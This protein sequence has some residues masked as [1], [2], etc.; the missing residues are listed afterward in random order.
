MVITGLPRPAHSSLAVM[1]QD[2]PVPRERGSLRGGNA[3]IRGAVLAGGGDHWAR[4]DDRLL[5]C[6]GD[7]AGAPAQSTGP[8][9]GLP[10]AEPENGERGQRRD[11]APR[12]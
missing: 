3:F 12:G 2:G 11:A 9:A 8:S 5:A 1:A 6:A 7:R 10:L 4:P